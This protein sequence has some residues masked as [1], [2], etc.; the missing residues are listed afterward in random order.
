MLNINNEISKSNIKS[1]TIQNKYVFVYVCCVLFMVCLYICVCESL[2][3]NINYKTKHQIILVAGVPSSQALP[4]YI[5]TAPPSVCVPDVLG[6]LP[7]WIQNQ[8]NIHIFDIYIYIYTSFYDDDCFYYH[9]WRNNV[10]I[11]FG[12]LSSFLT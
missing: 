1:I 6:A 10:V 5:I 4:G 12:T 8:K 11:A 2:L 9:S 3:K 7:V